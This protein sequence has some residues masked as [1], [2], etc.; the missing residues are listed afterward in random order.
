MAWV[1]P[2]YN[3]VAG[4]RMTA[5]DMNRI[6]GNINYLNSTTTLKTNWTDND[7]VSVTAWNTILRWLEK[8]RT[9]LGYKTTLKP[10]TAQTYQNVNNIERLTAQLKAYADLLTL[11]KSAIVYVGDGVYTSETPE[12]WSRD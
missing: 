8:A 7:I 10:T 11:Q 5:A 6:C 3:R 4:A 2:V 12:N 9:A 1:T